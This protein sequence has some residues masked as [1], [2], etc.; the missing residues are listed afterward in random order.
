ME[1]SSFPLS[2]Q[3]CLKEAKIDEDKRKYLLLF[4]DE[5]QNYI[6]NGIKLNLNEGRKYKAPLFSATQYSGQDMSPDFRQAIAGN[7]NI[8]IAGMNNDPKTID[9][10][11]TYL[12]LPKSKVAAIPEHHFMARVG[13]GFAFELRTTKYFL[14][15]TNSMSSYEWEETKKV[16]ATRYYRKP[17]EEKIAVTSAEDIYSVPPQKLPPDMFQPKKEKMVQE[18]IRKEKVADFSR[19]VNPAFREKQDVK[20]VFKEKQNIRVCSNKLCQAILDGLKIGN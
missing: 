11:A 2:F 14:R 3:L 15:D 18:D 20:P 6:N 19:N 13:K 9:D 4:V 7:T 8:K 17:A 10:M 16:Q 5:L 12:D 1:N